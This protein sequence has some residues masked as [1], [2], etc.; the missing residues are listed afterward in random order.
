LITINGQPIIAMETYPPTILFSPFPIL[1]T[2]RL[3]LRRITPAD[4]D[5]IFA[6]RSNA[7]TMQYIP[8]PVAK[9][10]QD[11]LDYISIIDKGIEDNDFIHWA[12][13]PKENAKLIGMICLIR[14]QPEDFR[15]EVGYI[16]SPESRGLGIMTEALQAVISYAFNV[17]HYHSLAAVIDPRNLS[18]EMVLVR[19]NFIKE[20]HFKECRYYNGTFL[21]DVVYSLLKH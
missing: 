16:L 1:E 8:R 5:E 14:F 21:D 17:L 13:C 9:S 12:I 11:A 15:T 6:I 2:A 18:S 4:V 10:K 19:A 7:E 3:V 20:A